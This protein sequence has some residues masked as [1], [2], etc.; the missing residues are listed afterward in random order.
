M[1]IPEPR[2][3]GWPLQIRQALDDTRLDPIGFVSQPC[4]PPAK[5]VLEDLQ[6]G[7]GAAVDGERRAERR[8]R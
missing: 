6:L 1:P 2:P 5:R 3:R 7:K 8:D 4:T